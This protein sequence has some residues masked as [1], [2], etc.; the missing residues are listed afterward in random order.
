MFEKIVFISFILLTN[1]IIFLRNYN[2]FI[3]S[4]MTQSQMN[5]IFHRRSLAWQI[6]DSLDQEKLKQGLE[7]FKGEHNFFNFTVKR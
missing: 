6:S 3:H 5:N 2:Y 1:K 7:T 4:K